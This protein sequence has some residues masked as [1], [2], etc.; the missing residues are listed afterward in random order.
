MRGLLIL[1]TVFAIMLAARGKRQ[2]GFEPLPT[3][4]MPWVNVP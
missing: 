3:A 2:N 1:L 4:S